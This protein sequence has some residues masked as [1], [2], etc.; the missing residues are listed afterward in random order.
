MAAHRKSKK[1]RKA[2][3]SHAR[4]DKPGVC[5]TAKFGGKAWCCHTKRVHAFGRSLTVLRAFCRKP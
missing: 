4:A 5:H 2:K 3:R 1:S